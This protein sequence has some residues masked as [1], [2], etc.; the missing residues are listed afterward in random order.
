MDAC[1]FEQTELDV[2]AENQWLSAGE[3]LCLRGLRFPKRRADWRLGRWTAKCA[4]AAYL[5]LPCDLS[6]LADI[7]IRAAASGAPQAFLLNQEAPLAISLSHRDGT[8]LCG[9]APPG[10]SLGC[11]LELIEPRSDAFVADYF[12]ASER[13]LVEQASANERHVLITLLWSAKESALKAL[14]AGLRLD[15]NSVE[16]SLVGGLSDQ[17]EDVWGPLHVR[18]SGA[19]LFSGWWRSDDQFVRTVVSNPSPNSPRRLPQPSQSLAEAQPLLL[20]R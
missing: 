12:T 9:V 15:T 10:T 5:D 13:A 6:T 20:A 7:E 17:N 4:V 18:Y 2:P 3:K 8:A 11:D 16:V 19:Q 14:H 1:W